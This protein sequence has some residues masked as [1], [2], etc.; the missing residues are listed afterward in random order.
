LR[1]PDRISRLLGMPSL[2]T[3]PVL[4]VDEAVP[5]R[6]GGLPPGSLGSERYRPVRTAVG[7]P[8]RMHKVHTLLVTS[9][10]PGGGKTTHLAKLA[11]AF[12]KTGRKVVLV[13]ADMRRPRLHRV[14]GVAR[15][16]GLAEVLANKA[17]LSEALLRPKGEEFDLLPA[18]ALPENPTD[19]LAAG[20]WP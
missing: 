3:L 15:A 8:T 2:C 16:P 11:A 14:F 7:F 10:I 18:G 17:R 4:P 20:T 13:D 6:Q 19:L 12:A 9:G 1:D 5:E